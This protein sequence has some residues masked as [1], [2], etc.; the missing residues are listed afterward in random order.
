LYL[1]AL[2]FGAYDEYVKN[3]I[4]YLLSMCL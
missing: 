2:L 1:T 4:A 3:P